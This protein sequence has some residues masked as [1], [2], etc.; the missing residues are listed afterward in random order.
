[1]DRLSGQ[2]F[3]LG[4]L[5]GGL[6]LALN[7]LFIQFSHLFG[8]PKVTAVKLSL[9][10]AGFWWALFGT[11]S[12]CLFQEEKGTGY[13]HVT[14]RSAARLGFRKAWET[15][16][17]VAGYKQLLLFLLAF[18]IYN[19]GVQTVI[20]MA[21]IYGKE[22]LHFSVGTLLGT[23]LMVQFIGV[24]G[25]LLMSWV[26]QRWG[27]KRTIMGGLMAWFGVTLFAYRMEASIE[28]WLLGI[29][30]G[31]ILGGTQALSRSLY[32]RLIPK[33]RSAQFFGYYSVF[34][35]F[36]SIW[37]PIIFALIRQLTGTSRLSILSLSSFFLVGWALLFFVKDRE[38]S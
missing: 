19:D 30:I 15:T 20:K 24:G 8:V 4:Y 32:G 13:R 9:A 34:A 31:L 21:T 25:A 5:G 22:E 6:L 10:S 36:S 33:E 23:L 1:M 38:R 3:A 7:I 28:F 18:M 35:K 29:V 14:L 27:T 12:F 17:M 2:G 11:L 26:A 16:R 37:G